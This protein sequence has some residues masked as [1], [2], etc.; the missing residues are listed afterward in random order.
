M[1]EPEKR[2]RNILET[3]RIIK[4]RE[5][6]RRKKARKGV[7]SIRKNGVNLRSIMFNDRDGRYV[8]GPHND[9]LLVESYIKKFLVKR[10]LID[11]GSVVNLINVDA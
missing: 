2:K 10:H 1:D 4:G 7:L 6:P 11:E 5:Q 9:A 8:K 3:V